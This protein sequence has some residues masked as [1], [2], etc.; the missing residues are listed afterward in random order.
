VLG[1]GAVLILLWAL[2][3]LSFPDFLKSQTSAW[4]AWL[5]GGSVALLA[6]VLVSLVQCPFD[7]FAGRVVEGN[8]RQI[9][10]NSRYR[11][12]HA[13]LFGVLRWVVALTL[14]GAI[15]GY[16]SYVTPGGWP[17][18]VPIAMFSFGLLQLAL[19]IPPGPT[20]HPGVARKPW[21]QQVAQ[22]L[23]SVG[24]ESPKLQFYDH[25]ERS[26][27]GGWA[28]IGKLRV[29]FVAKTLWDL[30][31]RTAAALLSR[32]IAHL[33]LGHRW[34]SFLAALAWTLAGCVVASVVLPS[35]WQESPGALV[36]A[37]A[38][39]L[40]TWAWVSLLFVFPALGRWQVLSADR[41]MLTSGFTLEES[42]DALAALSEC[43]KPDETL[44]PVI[45]FVFHPIP[46]MSVRRESLRAAAGRSTSPGS[47][48]MTRPT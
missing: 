13:Y 45:A 14:T 33:N 36:F 48:Q 12:G 5:A 47:P 37:L 27:A 44:P 7:Y 34:L 30:P 43:N 10:M 28:G 22:E 6:G 19:P 32:E 16:V 42:L 35:R 9:E 20:A 23:R 17:V 24:I 21:L 1:I 18:L 11:W 4:P 38:A 26:L 15:V 8:F 40:S 25:G 46:P 2:L 29:L 3:A 41:A 39:V 31:P